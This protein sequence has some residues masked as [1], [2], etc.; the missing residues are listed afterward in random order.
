MPPI[1]A[2]G[3]AAGGSLLGGI[4]GRP[5][6]NPQQQMAN[7]ATQQ[8]NAA[9][10]NLQAAS[11]YYQNLL[12]GNPAQL[13]Q[14]LGPTYA[15]VNPAF[16]TA[17]NN[18]LQSAY[19]RGGG[20]V[21]GIANLQSQRANTI[22]S[23]ASSAIASAPAALAALGSGQ[24]QQA[25]AALGGAQQAGVQNTILQNQSASNFGSFLT[26]L[27][28]GFNMNQNQNPQTAYTTPSGFNPSAMLGGYGSG[29]AFNPAFDPMAGNPNAVFNP[30]SFG[31]AGSFYFP[32]PSNY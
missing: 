15:S 10:P 4:L 13:N 9:Q 18:L 29:S 5:N 3:I 30:T 31:G 21:S 22:G 16:N 1:A 6:T 2:A 32:V 27:M 7:I 26:R 12:S 25:L 28:S 23:A 8:W 17:Q 24:G 20:L 11:T 14:A 19:A